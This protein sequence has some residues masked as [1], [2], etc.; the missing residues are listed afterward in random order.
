MQ[1]QIIS[2]FDSGAHNADLNKTVSRLKKDAAYKDTSVVIIVPAFGSVPTKVVAS[3]LSMY[4]PPNQRVVRLFAVGMEVGEAYSSCIESILAHPELSKYKYILTMEHD[5]SPP[6]DGLV[7][8]IKQM[9]AHP[10][11]CCIGGLYF[12]KGYGGVAQIWGDPKDPVLNFRPQLP[13]PAG[14]L[15]ECCGTGMGFN[16]WRLSM[17]KDKKLRKPWFKTTSDTNNGAMTQDLYFA[18]DA[19]QHGYR[20]AVDCSVRVGHY[21][22]EGR[23]GEPDKVW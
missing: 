19:R 12:T 5:N 11:F 2:S 17:F 1:P 7:N 22:L 3:W 4:T 10:E 8:L 6:P 14:G 23:F 9:E 13:D 20:F 16:L 18:K 21:D 15:V